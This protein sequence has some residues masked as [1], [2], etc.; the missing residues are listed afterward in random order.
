[1]GICSIDYGLSGIAKLMKTTFSETSHLT[2][3]EMK[4]SILDALVPLVAHCSKS[5]SLVCVRQWSIHTVARGTRTLC[6][7]NACPISFISFSLLPPLHC[8]LGCVCALWFLIREAHPFASVFHFHQRNALVGRWVHNQ[9]YT[10]ENATRVLRL[11]T[12]SCKGECYYSS[13]CVFDAA[14]DLP[15]VQCLASRV[16]CFY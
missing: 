3:S 9:R 16:H 6:S 7:I 14:V 15:Q 13:E 2:C 8:W 5:E 4:D 10:A 11:E 1:M 12:S